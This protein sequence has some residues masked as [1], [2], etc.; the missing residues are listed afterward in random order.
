MKPYHVLVEMARM[1]FEERMQSGVRPLIYCMDRL[2]GGDYL[3]PFT[4]N[5]WRAFR[6]GFLIGYALFP[7]TDAGTRRQHE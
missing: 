1:K 2:A 5:E 3:S 6:D 7:S 4:E